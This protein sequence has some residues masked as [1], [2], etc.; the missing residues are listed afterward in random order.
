[1]TLTAKPIAGTSGK[2]TPESMSEEVKIIRQRVNSLGVNESEVTQQGSDNIVVSVPGKHD[3]RTLDLVGQTALL[4]F[5]PVLYAAN[6]G[7][8]SNQ[9]TTPTPSGSA[10]PSANASPGT[11]TPGAKPSGQPR[12]LTQDLVNR[13]LT[14]AT[15]AATPAAATPTPTPGAA[16]GLSS[17]LGNVPKD[18]QDKF[19]SLDCTQAKNRAGGDN[20]DPAKPTVACAQDGTAKYL[21]APAAVKGTDVPTAS[22]QLETA[23]QGVVTGQWK[24]VLNLNGKGTRDFSDVT[25]Q[26]AKNSQPQNQFAIVLDGLVVSAPSV[27]QQINSSSAEITGNFT[28]QSAQDLA[29]VLKNGA[30]PLALTKSDSQQV[31]ATLGGDQLHGGLVAGAIGLGLVVLYALFYYGG[32]GFVAIMSLAIAGLLTYAIAVLLG[33]V[34]GFTLNLAGVAGLIVSIGITADSFVVFFERLRDEV[35]DGRTL[36]TAVEHGWIRARRTVLVAD[37]VSFLAAAVLYFVSVGTVKGFAFTLGLTTLIDVAVVFLFT[38]PL[39]TLLAG[40]RFF[41]GGHRFSGLDPRRLGARTKTSPIARR[42]SAGPA[43]ASSTKEA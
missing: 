29:N 23:G 31:T 24:V 10:K 28:Q 8:M 12:P 20:A 14:A 3:Q 26:L 30:L 4:Y 13:P 38:K 7:P 15:P 36:R 22:A 27:N 35:R 11:A 43:P 21:L 1:V 33:P 37:F 32:L 5:R 16:S 9:P 6:P 18:V 40:T 19:V 2:I 39:I 42:R 17:S 34:M 41:G 25:A